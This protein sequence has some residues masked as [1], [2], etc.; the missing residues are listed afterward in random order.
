ME[1]AEEKLE[2]KKNLLRECI[3]IQT[4]LVEQT[5]EAMLEAQTSANEQDGATEEGM[6]SFKAQRQQD[7]EIY[8]KQFDERLE[9]LKNLKA[10]FPGKHMTKASYGAV[11]IT[12]KHKYLIAASLGQLK[13]GSDMYFAISTDSPIFQAMNQKAKGEKFIFRDTQF[14]VTDVF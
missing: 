11:V 2:I 7:R 4:K 9:V 1:N 12:N 14:T 3:N 13:L 5:R 8:A 6:E 10:L